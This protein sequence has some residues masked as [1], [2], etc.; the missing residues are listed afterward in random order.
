MVKN[1]GPGLGYQSWTFQLWDSG[2]VPLPLWSQEPPHPTCKMNS[3]LPWVKCLVKSLARYK[4]PAATSTVYYQLFSV[5]SPR[6]EG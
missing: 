5:A 3:P 1:V 4:C 2:Q 6:S